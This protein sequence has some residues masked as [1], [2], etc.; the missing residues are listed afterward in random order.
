MQDKEDRLERLK[1]SVKR[2]TSAHA[3]Q[4][5]QLAEV[6]KKL[7]ELEDTRLNVY[8][9]PGAKRLQVKQAYNTVKISSP[10][11]KTWNPRNLCCRVWACVLPESTR[12]GPNE[13]SETSSARE[14]FA[15]CLGKKEEEKSVNLRLRRSEGQT[16]RLTISLVLNRHVACRL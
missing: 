10:R 12:I 1:K 3:K 4:L 5:E 2:F 8:I 15:R 11:K 9:A 6:E 16:H 14:N 13:T 7:E